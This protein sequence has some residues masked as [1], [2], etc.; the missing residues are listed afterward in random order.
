VRVCVF[1]CS[2]AHACMWAFN[3]KNVNAI[4]D[5]RHPLKTDCYINLLFMS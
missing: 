2:C 1:V 4:L 3:Q 5:I